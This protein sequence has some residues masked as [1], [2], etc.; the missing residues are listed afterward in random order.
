MLVL[1][2]HNPGLR[3]GN[4]AASAGI[5]AI[6]KIKVVPIDRMNF[7]VSGYIAASGRCRTGSWRI[8]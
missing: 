8:N 2:C 7:L 4:S 6:A 5:A 1:T 3:D